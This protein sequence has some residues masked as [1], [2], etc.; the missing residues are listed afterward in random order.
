MRRGIDR[1]RGDLRSQAG[2]KGRR[3]VSNSEQIAEANE[4]MCMW[5]NKIL[6]PNDARGELSTTVD[7]QLSHSHGI[8]GKMISR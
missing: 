7:S 2:G 6:R 1:G 5:S 4:E 8:R 3:Q